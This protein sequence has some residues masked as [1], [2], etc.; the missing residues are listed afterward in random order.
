[1]RNP[2]GMPWRCRGVTGRIVISLIIQGSI[3]CVFCILRLN[4]KIGKLGR[5]NWK[6][7]KLDWGFE[8]VLVR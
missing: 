7:K 4:P 5:Q 6:Q 3:G 1:M 2:K 8:T